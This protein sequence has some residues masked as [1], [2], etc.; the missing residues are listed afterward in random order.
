MKK[1]ENSGILYGVGYAIWGM[2]YGEKAQG[3]GR[4]AKK[5]MG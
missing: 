4:R 1:K 3:A 2:G 5:G